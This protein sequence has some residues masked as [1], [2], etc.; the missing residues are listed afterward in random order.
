MMQAPAGI[1]W[2]SSLLSRAEVAGSGEALWLRGDV[3]AV[4]DWA[5]SRS[6]GIVTIEVYAKVDLARGV[7]Q[8]ELTI[9]PAWS[10]DETWAQYVARSAAQSRE[11]L[12]SDADGGEARATDL[13]FFAVVSEPPGAD[14][15]GG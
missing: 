5:E 2:P 6:L 9:E 14:P 10:E 1:E 11:K 12:R 8:R 4:I 15:P 7:F 13:Y 3:A